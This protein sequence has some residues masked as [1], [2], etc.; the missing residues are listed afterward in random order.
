MAPEGEGGEG[1]RV[2]LP[3]EDALVLGVGW[4]AVYGK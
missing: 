4:L 2:L 1:A 3:V